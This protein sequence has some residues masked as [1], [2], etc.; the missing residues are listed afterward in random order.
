VKIGELFK[1]RE[2][3][4]YPSPTAIVAQEV[5]AAHS[6]YPQHDGKFDDM[7]LLAFRSRT[8]AKNLAERTLERDAY[9]EKYF[10]LL[11]GGGAT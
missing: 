2:R 5:A 3:A 7:A 6:M 11:N 10:D 4:Q 1:D 8:L 9:R